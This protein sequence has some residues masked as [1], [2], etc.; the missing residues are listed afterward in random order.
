[1]CAPCIAGVLVYTYE[2]SVR[3]NDLSGVPVAW[4]RSADEYQSS[5]VFGCNKLSSRGI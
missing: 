5:S 3:A 1:M 4:A 2:E